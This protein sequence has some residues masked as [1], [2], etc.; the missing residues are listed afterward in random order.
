MDCDTLV[1]ALNGETDVVRQGEENLLVNSPVK[2]PVSL[3]QDHLHNLDV[4]FRRGFN[5]PQVI[6]AL[7]T[8]LH[9]IHF[10]YR[11]RVEN[12]THFA[13][14]ANTLAHHDSFIVIVIRR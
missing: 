14:K 10:L 1:I 12:V 5:Q 9:H 4:L 3:R 2:L 11:G 8:V 7:L 13:V 6:A